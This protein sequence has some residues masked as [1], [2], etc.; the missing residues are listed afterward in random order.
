MKKSTKV[1][2]NRYFLGSLSAFL[3]YSK[4]D[5]IPYILF[6]GKMSHMMKI[7]VMEVSDNSENAF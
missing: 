7:L 5:P 6:T 3:S 2:V 4:T 1:L